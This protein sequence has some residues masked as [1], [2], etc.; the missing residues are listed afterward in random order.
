MI[1]G[2]DPNEPLAAERAT[3]GDYWAAIY[4]RRW[5]IVL[6][7][8]SSAAFSYYFSI[9]MTP[10]YESKTEFYVPADVAGAAMGPEQGKPRMPSGEQD[11]AKAYSLILKG[12][13]SLKKISERFPEK[14]VV[15][16]KKDVDIAITRLGLIQVYVRDTDPEVA[17]RVANGF[18]E[19]FDEFNR[20][21]VEQQMESTLANLD[22]EI[23]RVEN[24]REAVEDSRRRF[25]Q[26][27]NIALLATKLQE[28]ENQ[29]LR[30]EENRD[31]AMVQLRSI[32]GQLSTLE[33]R[34]EQESAAY[35]AGEVVTISAV[36]ATLRE[37]LV[38]LEVEMAGR[39]TELKDDHPDIINLRQRIAETR[40]G[41]ARELQREVDSRAKLPGTLY[42]TIREQLT[43]LYVEQSATQAR[44]EALG[45][46]I[47]GVRR[48]IEGMPDLAAALA[49]FD[50]DIAAYEVQLAGLRGQRNGIVA[51]SLEMRS[52]GIVLEKAVPAAK[53]DPIFPILPLNV[54]IATLAGLVVGV[55]YALLLDYINARKH[56]QKLRRI[57]FEQWARALTEGAGAR[58]GGAA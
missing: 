49:R 15:D 3:L 40:A 33:G 26:E 27:H 11:H 1:A 6:V 8:A 21:I 18:V 56:L 7:I 28:L 17:A 47:D 25:Q 2:P 10:Q 39:A 54:A 43:N 29:A 50:K 34:L 53:N 48:R 44:I 37:S 31:M 36:M 12:L 20:R 42:E 45:R 16:L 14:T 35:H 22:E 41:L 30:L 19:Y 9:R 23:S 55:F 5:I 58:E 38:S 4:R 52:S 24:E 46:V 13:E 57:Q 32:E 51:R